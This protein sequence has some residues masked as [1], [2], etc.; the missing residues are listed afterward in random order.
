MEDNLKS[1][2]KKVGKDFASLGKDFGKTFVKTVKKGVS[3]ATEWADEK[4]EKKPDEK[5]EVPA[6]QSRK[7]ICVDVPASEE[8]EN[9]VE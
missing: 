2:W 8:N 9:K 1:G 6:A 5:A 3:K 4:E 7:V